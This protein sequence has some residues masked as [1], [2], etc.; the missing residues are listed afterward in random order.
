MIDASVLGAGPIGD[1]GN[2]LV[3]F[4]RSYID[5]YL[6]SL[7]LMLFSPAPLHR[8]LD[9]ELLASALEGV[10]APLERDLL[11]AIDPARFV[12]RPAGKTAVRE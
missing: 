4:R 2:V 6:P 12:L 11:E 3:S 7:Q 10:P 9:K 8:N 5:S 1:D